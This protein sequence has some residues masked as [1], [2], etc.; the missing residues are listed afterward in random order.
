MNKAKYLLKIKGSVL[1]SS[2]DFI[3]FI[4]TEFCDSFYF[5]FIGL[6]KLSLSIY[7]DTLQD[8]QTIYLYF[9]KV[10][11]VKISNLDR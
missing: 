11:S 3:R 5:E 9:I 7:L 8:V 6:D 2:I 4:T 10:D 1:A